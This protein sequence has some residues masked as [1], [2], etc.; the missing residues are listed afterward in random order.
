M[1]ENKVVL[2]AEQIIDKCADKTRS[3]TFY[4]KKLYAGFDFKNKDYSFGFTVILSEDYGIFN[5]ECAYLQ[6]G[7]FEDFSKDIRLY[8][9]VK[10][11][12]GY[13][14]NEDVNAKLKREFGSSYISSRRCLNVS[15]NINYSLNEWPASVCFKSDYYISKILDLLQNGKIKFPYANKN[16]S[17]WLI[18]QCKVE[19]VDPE[20]N[21]YGKYICQPGF[22]ALMNAYL[23]WEYYTHFTQDI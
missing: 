11:L 19:L 9:P 10:T 4:G 12:G 21:K 13:L 2:S 5:I 20:N 23:A 7:T 14:D 18:E 6:D 1:E 8:N 17:D 22:Y 3:M 16:E 15:D